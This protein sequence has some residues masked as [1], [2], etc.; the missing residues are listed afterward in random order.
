MDVSRP[1]LDRA[2]MRGNP[3]GEGTRAVVEWREGDAATLPFAKGEADL[4]ISRFGVMF[5][6]DPVQAFRNVRRALRPGGRLV[7]LCWQALEKNAWVSVP[8][9]AMLQV[10][11][12]PEP[13][14]PNAP[15]P[16]AF[17]D[18]VHVSGILLQAGF[19]SVESAAVE[20]ALATTADPNAAADVVLEDALRFAV[21]L[22]PASAL[23]REA[24]PATSERAVSA[25]RAALRERS[26]NGRP[27]LGA[28][29]WIYAATNPAA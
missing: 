15:G 11:P 8:R 20:A 16:F 21:E 23:L 12:A 1:M 17:A 6:A 14:P 9:A 5:F 3:A 24:D 27:S 13:M 2:R 26:G 29:C 7:M 18:A 25:V 28:A 22:G 10:V 19:A 4:L